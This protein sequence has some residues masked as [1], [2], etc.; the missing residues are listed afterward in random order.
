[1]RHNY[2]LPDAKIVLQYNGYY[3]FVLLLLLQLLLL[4]LSLYAHKRLRF[5]QRYLQDYQKHLTIEESS[6]YFSNSILC[7]IRPLCKTLGKPLSIGTYQ[8]KT[9]NKHKSLWHT[10]DIDEPFTAQ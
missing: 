4:L 5:Q 6:N 2:P 7:L 3:Y 9:K 1:M 8:L 10:N